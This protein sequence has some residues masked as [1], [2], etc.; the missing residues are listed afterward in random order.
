MGKHATL[1]QKVAFLVHLEYVNCAEAA[2][3]ADITYKTMYD[4][5]KRASELCVERAKQG[6]PPPYEEQ[7]A[8]KEGSGAQSKISE[9]EIERLLEACTTNKKQRKKLWIQVAREEG[10]FNLH[11]RTIEKKLCERGV[12]NSVNSGTGTLNERAKPDQL[13]VLIQESKAKEEKL[14]AEGP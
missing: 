10:F 7:V 14:G 12:T 4:I 2:R 11:R 5:K 13:V 3:R 6:L 9:A 1:C 8:K